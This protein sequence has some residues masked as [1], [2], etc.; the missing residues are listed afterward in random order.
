VSR[1]S[2]GL[3]RLPPEAIAK[4]QEDTLASIVRLM[5][6]FVGAASFCL[7]SLLTPDSSLL[8]N[9]VRLNVP[10]AGP[11]S[12]L[13]FIIVGPALLIAL[14]VYLHIYIEHYRRLEPIGRLLRPIRPPTL[15]ALKN[16]LLRFMIGLVLYALLPF[17]MIAFTLKAAVLSTWV[18]GLVFATYAVIVSHVLLWFT[19]SW[20]WRSRASLGLDVGIIFGIAVFSTI[21]TLAVSVLLVGQSPRRPFDLFRADLPKQWFPDR[22]L[23]GA[24]LIRANLAETNFAGAD[25]GG[26]NLHYAN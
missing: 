24:N 10:F 2:R 17:T 4:A 14:R 16:P 13:G 7:L 9:G 18:P 22:D 8:T 3:G 15:M 5:L 1:T 23:S 11:V 6:T 19:R 21:A 20:R 25:L 12:F 26:A